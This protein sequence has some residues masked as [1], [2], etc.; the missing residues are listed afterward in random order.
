MSGETFISSDFYKDYIQVFNLK[1]HILELQAFE[2]G[3]ILKKIIEEGADTRQ[4]AQK[5]LTT[6]KL[7]GVLGNLQMTEKRQVKRPMISLTYDQKTK[8][9]SKFP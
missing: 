9:I 3:L 8:Q 6:I 1:P 2:A 7:D 4:E 5:M